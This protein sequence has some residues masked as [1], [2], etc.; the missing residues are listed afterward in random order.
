MQIRGTFLRSAV[1]RRV[2]ALFVASSFLPVAVLAFLS[3][4]QVD[5]LTRTH[6]EQRLRRTGSA[7]MHSVYDRLLGARFLLESLSWAHVAHDADFDPLRV[8]GDGAFLRVSRLV[9]ADVDAALSSPS[10]RQRPWI[11]G[12]TRTHLEKGEIALLP[13]QAGSADR[14][15]WL[16]RASGPPQLTNGIVIAQLDPAYLWGKAED[17]AYG[18]QVCVFG[19]GRVELN[20][21]D[22]ALAELARGLGQE[23]LGAIKDSRDGQW[24][25]DSKALFLRPKFGASDWT[26]VTMQLRGTEATAVGKIARS[27]LAVAVLTLLLASFLSLIHIRRTLVPIERLVEGTRRIAD[28]VFDRPVQVERNDEFAELAQSLNG[29][30]VRL[31]RQIGAMR[32]LSEIDQEILTRLDLGRIVERVHARLADLLPK[33]TRGVIVY[34]DMSDNVATAFLHA[35]DQPPQ[36][37]RMALDA[38]Q[39]GGAFPGREGRWITHASIQPLAAHHELDPLFGQAQAFAV[40][41]LL[42]ERLCGLLLIGGVAESQ[43]DEE[44]SCQLRDLGDRVAVALA[45]RARERQLMY[46]ARHDDLTDLPNRAQLHEHLVHALAKAQRDA[47]RLALLF[48]DLDRFKAFNDT[49]GHDGG[50]QLLRLVGGRLAASVRASDLVARI[51]GDEFVVVLSAIGSPQEAAQV[52]AHIVANLA[53]PVRVHE[54][55]CA[56]GASIGIAL[57]PGDGANADELLRH[58][59]R[60]MYRAK[61]AGRGCVVFYE[62]GKNVE[63]QQRAEFEAELRQALARGQ[64]EVHYQ[65]RVEMG[66]CRFVSVE[67]LARWRHPQ[68]GWVSP[69]RFIPVAE[70]DGLIETIGTW[71]LEQACRQLAAW[72]AAGLDIERVSVNVSGRQLRTDALADTVRRA[73]AASGLP[74]TALELEVTEGLLLENIAAV[75]APLVRIRDTGVSIALDDFGTG[76]SSLNYLRHLPIDVLKIDESFVRDLVED[77]S[78]RGIVQ[79]IIA[80]AHVLK[81]SVTATGVETAAQADLLREWGCRE[82]QGYYF[83][84]PVAPDAL[85]AL[86]PQR[87]QRSTVACSVE[88]AREPQLT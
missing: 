30:A 72:R 33:G 68:W 25:L 57:F 28:E 16:A 74:P 31:G 3:H 21:S 43:I 29:M 83:G 1:A 56:V 58:A 6:A 9:G 60:A 17:L 59:D 46:R 40:P 32:A 78:A 8:K 34:D 20:C 82:A 69:G 75:T 62:E 26:F 66:A 10:G 52:A 12:V 67:A 35:G 54:T 87:A 77:A 51:G 37:H 27:F 88:P 53:K 63:E 22:P 84:R 79:A 55:D 85:G 24:A 71:V 23:Q 36:S 73:L 61:S 7:H 18:I 44:M 65:P 14:A 49:M 86:L 13:P 41:L 81:K 70:D 76:S 15:P 47:S 39:L 45:A 2:F 48:V 5:E 42:R 4:A 19:A 50:D 64:L 38:E 80:M 11:D